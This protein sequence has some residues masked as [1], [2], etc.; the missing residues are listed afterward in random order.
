VTCLKSHPN[1]KDQD[2][3]QNA[4]EKLVALPGISP[5]V[6][7]FVVGILIASNSSCVK[8]VPRPCVSV[9]VS[10]NAQKIRSML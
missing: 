5:A 2:Q 10:M 4:P 6:S 1:R 8:V 3:N 9:D 7:K